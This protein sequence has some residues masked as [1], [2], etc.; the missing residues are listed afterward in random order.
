VLKV[1][2]Y[3]QIKIRDQ[4]QQNI[5]MLEARLAQLDPGPVVLEPPT[6]PTEPPPVHNGRVTTPRATKTTPRPRKASR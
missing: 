3:D 5:N 4:T 6:E 2:I 1:A